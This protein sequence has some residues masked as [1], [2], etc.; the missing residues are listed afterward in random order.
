MRPDQHEQIVIA[1]RQAA[2]DLAGRRSIRDLEETL[3]QIVASAVKTIPGVDAAS[4]SMTE[5]GRIE[6]RH[7][8]SEDIR[9]LDETQSQLHEGPCISAITDPPESGLVVAEDFAGPD[10]ERWPSFAPRAVEAGYRALMST[11][12]SI[13]GGARAA[14]NLYSRAANAFD[15]DPRT[16]AGLFGA[17]AALLLYG[18]VQAAHLVKAVDS[19]DLIGQAKGILM[20]RFTVDDEAAFQMLVQSSQTTNMKLTAVAKWL[21]H[22][23]KAKQSGPDERG[24]RP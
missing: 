13:D 22:D 1:L 18:A 5:D 3:G 21:T 11:Q 16:L 23:V 9:K 14:L 8:T 17:Q 12:L 19:R 2:R 4:I 10:A 7:P 20:E 24:S 6:T 15:E